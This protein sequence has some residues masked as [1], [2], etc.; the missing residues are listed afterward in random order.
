MSGLSD[1]MAQESKRWGGDGKS[2]VKVSAQTK[3]EAGTAEYAE[4]TMRMLAGAS[5][6]DAGTFHYEGRECPVL[7]K[8]GGK[9]YIEL[10]AGIRVEVVEE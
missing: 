10:E 9:V 2:Y 8:R 5:R 3:A 7:W 1:L 6:R 4:R